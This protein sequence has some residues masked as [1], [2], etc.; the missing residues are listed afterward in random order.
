MRAVRPD[1]APAPRERYLAIAAAL[2]RRGGLETEAHLASQIRLAD[3]ADRL[4][5]SRTALYRRWPT[6][7]QFWID[8][9]KFLAYCNDFAQP[10]P[11]LPWNRQLG[12]LDERGEFDHPEERPRE[13]IDVVRTTMNGLQQFVLADPWIVV[14]AAQ[15]A[16]AEMPE[17]AHVRAKVEQG[18]L[19]LMT[20]E[21][22]ER[23]HR[24][25]LTTVPPLTVHDMSVAMW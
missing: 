25:S 15:L 8:L 21:I 10:E 13:T 1:P 9:S 22:A 6:R 19:D 2:A 16:Y 17:L 3:L 5:V 7:H 24:N 12:T 4:G 14:R 18:R 20:R 23:L 11:A